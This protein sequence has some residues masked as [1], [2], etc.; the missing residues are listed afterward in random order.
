MR[1]W[2]TC[3]L[4]CCLLMSADPFYAHSS[5]AAPPILVL[6][7]DGKVEF[8]R[9]GWTAHQ[10][11]IAGTLILPTDLIFP[12]DAT[13]LVMCPDG[14]VREF[15]STDLIPNSHLTCPGNT[16]DYIVG[17]PGQK[18]INIRRG[19][20]QS[21]TVPYLISPRETVVRTPQVTIV[22]N[23]I[24]NV[25]TYAVT[26]YNSSGKVWTSDQLDPAKVSDGSIASVTLP[27]SLQE[28]TPYTVEICTLFNDTRHHCT[29]DADWSAGENLAFY[30]ISTPALNQAEAQVSDT[31]G[32]DTPES[33]YAR[34]VLL[35]QPVY[36]V[37]AGTRLGVNSEA[38]ALLERL[39]KDD[40]DA[41]MA[42]S[43][44]P[45]ALLGDLYRT[46]DLPLSAAKAYQYAEQLADPGTEAAANAALGLALT[47]PDD[48]ASIKYYNQALDDYA[49][50][51][52]KEA[53]QAR[54]T[55]LC[56]QLG[57]LKLDIERCA[58]Q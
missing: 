41:A 3:L 55:E 38:I 37:A 1:I 4:A 33:L 44:A 12:Q 6:K 56:G 8:T 20:R 40:P 17:Q 34:A 15:L 21:S 13:L 25:Y 42:K 45:Y 53:F 51:L 5:K 35:S 26:L 11:V 10:I 27:Q 29:T 19:G 23:P 24:P 32:K 18:R 57:D 39:T 7:I 30:F 49:A 52:T 58:A 46:I 14:T 43:P 47:S 16:A 31:L 48:A 50:F 28:K 22:W 54:L 9:E 2:I 36:Q